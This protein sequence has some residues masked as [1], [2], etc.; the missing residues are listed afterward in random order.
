ML[1]LFGLLLVALTAYCFYDSVYPAAAAEKWRADGHDWF[2]PANWAVMA[3][4]FVGAIYA[5]IL[6]AVRSKKGVGIPTRKEA[7]AGQTDQPKNR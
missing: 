1:V 6:A 4:A 7:G 3:V 5:F 2:V